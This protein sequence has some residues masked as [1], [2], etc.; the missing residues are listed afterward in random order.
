MIKEIKETLTNVMC[1]YNICTCVYRQGW[2][3]R[4][5]KHKSNYGDS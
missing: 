1:V 4:E 5:E 3:E 2:R